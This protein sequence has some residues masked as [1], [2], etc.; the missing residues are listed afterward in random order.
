MAEIFRKDQSLSKKQIP[1]PIEEIVEFG[2]KLEL[3]PIHDM[4]SKSDIDGFLSN[5]P[6]HFL[7]EMDRRLN[8]FFDR[9]RRIQ[10]FI[11]KQI[12]IKHSTPSGSY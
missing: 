4:K 5:D 8:L 11:E 12:K 1:V 3:I 2:L 7:V 6:N 9:I 10:M